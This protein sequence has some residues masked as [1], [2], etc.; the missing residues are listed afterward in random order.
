M[1]RPRDDVFKTPAFQDLQTLGAPNFVQGLS[2]SSKGRALSNARGQTAVFIAL[3]FQILFV[4][5]AMTLNVALVIHDKI[6]LQNSVDLAAY[7]AAER[8]AEQ[9][10]AIA[11]MNYQIRQA[12][13]LLSWRYRVL[14]TLGLYRGQYQHPARSG[15]VTETLFAPSEAPSLCVVYKPQWFEVPDG[16]NL[17]NEPNLRIPALPQVPLIAGFIGVN[18][19]VTALSNQLIDAFNHSC[20]NLGAYNWWFAMGILQSYRIEQRNRKLMIYALANN[21]S[22]KS[23]DFTDISGSSTKAGAQQVFL[24]NLTF[25]NHNSQ[26]NFEM[27]NSLNGANPQVWLPEVSIAPTILYTDTVNSGGCNAVATPV[28][29]LPASPG[30]RANLINP[31]LFNAG[32]LEV[33]AANEPPLTDPYSFSIGVEKNPWVMAYV[34]VRA[35]TTPRQIFFP[36][37]PSVTLTA[38]GFAQPFG[39][40]IGPWYGSQWPQGAAQSTGQRTDPLLPPRPGPDGNV[41]NQNDPTRLPNYSRFPGDIYGLTT[42][43]AQNSM[44]NIMNIGIKFAYFTHMY[45][46][47]TAGGINDTLAWD[48]QIDAR[49]DYRSFEL[50]AIA[51]DLFDINYY[52]I[53]PNYAVNYLQTLQANAQQLQITPDIIVR[54]DLGTHVPQFQAYSVQDQMNDA[55]SIEIPQAFF[56]VRQKANLLTWW[57]QGE[58]AVNYV[59]PNERFGLC[60]LPDDQLKDKVPGSCAAMGGRTGYSVKL[61]NRNYLNSSLFQVGG[62]GSPTGAIV[63]PPQAFGW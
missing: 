22:S 49:P 2:K 44:A 59:F 11:H 47:F 40:S 50:A 5:F 26:V 6:N 12:W 25:A 14:G 10:N 13:K 63:N 31:S 51:P 3:I 48:Y 39:G 46:D 34:G 35:T 18:A 21:L 17:C 62:S 4:L 32:Q 52:S 55:S 60:G 16:E 33:W 28:Q 37:G 1:A 19:A 29:S 15:N 53:E 42:N 56:Y 23:D 58:G 36:F 30:A 54:G 24:K 45:D 38:R 57:A 27:L 20:D 7:Y 41:P 8:Q 61:V 9:L 43:L